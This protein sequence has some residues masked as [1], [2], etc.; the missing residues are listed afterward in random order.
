[1]PR[2]NGKMY[3]IHTIQLIWKCSTFFLNYPYTYSWPTKIYKSFRENSLHH[4]LQREEDSWRNNNLSIRRNLPL[5]TV[6]PWQN[7]WNSNHFHGWTGP[8][9]RTNL[10]QNESSSP[11]ALIAILVILD[12]NIH[13][14]DNHYG[15]IGFHDVKPT[16]QI[17]FESQKMVL[18]QTL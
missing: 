17:T 9:T 5:F 7:K 13:A 15:L 1:M 12:G 11:F 4:H 6:K 14:Q 10:P 3:V 16:S 18:H 8:R 2:L